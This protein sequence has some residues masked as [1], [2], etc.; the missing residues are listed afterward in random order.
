MV[1][2][3]VVGMIKI[4]LLLEQRFPCVDNGFGGW[5]RKILEEKGWSQSDLAR[6]ARRS[7]AAIS[8]AM[9]GKRGVGPALATS[10]ASALKIPREEAYRAAGLLPPTITKSELIERIITE[11]DDLPVEDKEQVLEY[12]DMMRRLKEKRRRKKL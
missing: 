9:S 11:I 10:I 7:R 2:G 12:I 3:D 5:L 1:I 4:W 8:D 6:A